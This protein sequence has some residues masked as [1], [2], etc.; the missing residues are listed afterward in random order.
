MNSRQFTIIQQIKVVQFTIVFKANRSKEV[1]IHEQTL[2]RNLKVIIHS[3]LMYFSSG[4]YIFD[5]QIQLDYHHFQAEL[6]VKDVRFQS[7]DI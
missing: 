7:Q 6:E 3:F 4:F 5:Q 2:H 1:T